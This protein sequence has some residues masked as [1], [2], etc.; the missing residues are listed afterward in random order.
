MD[1]E[2]S[3]EIFG[4]LLDQAL[5]KNGRFSNEWGEVRRNHVEPLLNE[6]RSQLASRG[7]QAK[8]TV[9]GETITLGTSHML[10]DHFLRFS[11]DG[12]RF[13]VQLSYMSCHSN[14]PQYPSPKYVLIVCLAVNE[15]SGV[16]TKKV[17]EFLE[18]VLAE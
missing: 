13:Q 6:A 15:I 12:D 14:I 8:V 18:T 4:K 9:E 2:H 3:G 1:T 11:P 10:A 7:L 16:A 17:Y 5:N